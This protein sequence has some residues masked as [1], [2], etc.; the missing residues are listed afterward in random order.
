VQEQVC[1][2]RSGPRTSNRMEPQRH[3]PAWVLVFA[4]SSLR[5]LAAALSCRGS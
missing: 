3:P 2:F 5:P 4:T 1:G